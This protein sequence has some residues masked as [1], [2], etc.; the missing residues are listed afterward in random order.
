MRNF[1]R[2]AGYS[3]YMMY[4]LQTLILI[5]LT[6][7]PLAA[8]AETLLSGSVETRVETVEEADAGPLTVEVAD[9]LSLSDS[10]KKK[11]IDLEICYPRELQEG[12]S[13]PVVIVSHAAVASGRDYRP[14]AAFWAS[15]GYVCILPSHD[16]ALATQIKPGQK[17][18]VFKIASLHKVSSKELER[19]SS[20]LDTVL[21]SLD[22]LADGLPGLRQ[23]T[24]TQRV[25]LVGHLDGARSAET[26]ASQCRD[27]RLK[28]VISITGRPARSPEHRSFDFEK[29]DKPMMVLD[30]AAEN[31]G[32]EKNRQKISNALAA[33]QDKDGLLVCVDLNRAVIPRPSFS[34]MRKALRGSNLS[35]SPVRLPRFGRGRDKNDAAEEQGVRV[36]PVDGAELPGDNLLSVL[37]IGKR[38]FETPG[39]KERIN[40]VMS[41]TLPFLDAYLKDRPEALSRLSEP[42]AH[43]FGPYVTTVVQRF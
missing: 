34:Q 39:R 36:S 17:V 24:D 22:L 41:L 14:L 26:L 42:D 8:G 2:D 6:F 13:Y 12:R 33:R 32:A 10:G 15:H 23:K 9:G 35:L 11:K 30:I 29:I 27:E 16:D 20:D 7:T 38:P 5:V 40:Y 19:R 1:S 25:A 43:K 21:A 3:F 18:S 28:A 31:S 4:M 37:G